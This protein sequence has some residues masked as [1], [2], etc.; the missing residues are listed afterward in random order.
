MKSP[1]SP[2]VF[3]VWSEDAAERARPSAAGP[4]ERKSSRASPVALVVAALVGA[5]L[6]SGGFVGASM[7]GDAHEAH[8]A[9]V[10]REEV[11]AAIADMVRDQELLLARLPTAPVPEISPDP[12]APCSPVRVERLGHC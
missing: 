9:A 8:D 12:R 2:V 5:V 11:A 7:F 3:E 1:T 4:G 10:V 6:A